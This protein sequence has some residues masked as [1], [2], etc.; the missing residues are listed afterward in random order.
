MK[1]GPRARTHLQSGAGG[2]ACQFFML[3]Y[4]RR[5]PHVQPE[6]VYIFVTWRLYGSL[7]VCKRTDRYLTPGHAF[8]AADRALDRC[9]SGPR[10]LEDP[11]IAG[12]VTETIQIG[13]KERHFYDLD[14][15]AIMPN[16]VHLLILPHVDLPIIMRWLKGSSARRANQLL[17][18]TGQ[19]F[20]QFESY[21]HW[22]RH[23]KELDK[24]G[25]YIERNPVSAGLVES[26]ELWL[27]PW[28]SAGWQ[29]KPPTPLR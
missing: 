9:C 10:W 2:F 23:R 8:V 29:A 1:R 26:E 27:W 20:W 28:S 17:G 4:R 6:S 5:L 24:I 22:V 16:H 19:P 15:W 3:E 12:I 7:P 13:E 21:D 18:R 11:R 14:A 25:R